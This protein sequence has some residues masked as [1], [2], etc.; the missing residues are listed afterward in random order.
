MTREEEQHLAI[1]EEGFLAP[2]IDDC[3]GAARD[4]YADWFALTHDANRAA[5][6]LLQAAIGSLAG[7]PLASAY[8]VATRLFVRTLSNFQGAVLLAERGLPV[9]AQTLVRSC[10]EA[11]L[12][13]GA[14]K[15]AKA[16]VLD[17]LDAGGRQGG[18]G[19]LKVLKTMVEAEGPDQAAYLAQ[20]HAGMA[21]LEATD[22][23]KAISLKELADQTQLLAPYLNFRQL[24]SNAAHASFSSMHAQLSIEGGDVTG[25]VLGPDLDRLP[26]TLALA[27]QALI[28]AAVF[29]SPVVGEFSQDA[30]FVTL[31][32][33]L[34]RLCDTLPGTEVL[35]LV[36]KD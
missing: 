30:M 3:V 35:V 13:I 9:E 14:L 36:P 10:F 34:A 32:E 8:V 5:Q 26:A 18:L 12:L 19:R 22:Q 1:S 25:L 27:C 20:V 21:A 31:H 16:E 15:D 28:Y 2:C 33:R 23:R 24:S 11:S 4:R 17:H 29:L 7:H 6:I